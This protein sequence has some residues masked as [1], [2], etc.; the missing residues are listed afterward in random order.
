MNRAAP[1]AWTIPALIALAS[2]AV[3]GSA[4]VA[5]YGFGLQPC[6]LCL[7]QRYPYM[8]TIA[9]GGLGVMAAAWPLGRRLCV[10]LA[11]AAFLAGAGVA[12]FHVGVEQ[13]WWE[14]LA[15]CSAPVIEPGMSVEELREVLAARSDVVPC[16]EPAWT[17]FGLSMAAYNLLVSLVLAGGTGMAL[18]RRWV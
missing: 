18:S 5:E 10:A 13:G 16:D 1:P 17:L 3:L 4:Y 6:A 15:S 11:G 2:V 9:L 14:G 8:A 12:G 7:W